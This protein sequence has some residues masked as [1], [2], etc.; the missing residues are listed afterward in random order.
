LAFLL[1]LSLPYVINSSSSF[2]VSISISIAD[3]RVMYFSADTKLFNDSAA[4]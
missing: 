3:Y 4:V 2:L 1:A